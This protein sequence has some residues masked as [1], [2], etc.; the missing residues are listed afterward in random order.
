MAVAWLLPAFAAKLGYLLGLAYMISRDTVPFL[1]GQSVGKKAMK[2]KVTTLEGDSL[3]GK[4][5]P[6]FIRNGVLIIPFFG[7]IELFVL[8]TR[9]NNPERGRRLGDE[10][11]KTKVVL[12]PVT[13]P[14]TKPD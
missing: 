10:W 4:W 9:E 8:L 2:L 7:L 1:G 11:A 12:A 6:T 5:E 3:V 13:T 14:E